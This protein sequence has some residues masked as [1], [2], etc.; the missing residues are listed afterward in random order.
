MLREMGRDKGLAS[1]RGAGLLFRLLHRSH[2]PHRNRRPFSLFGRRYPVTPSVARDRLVRWRRVFRGLRMR[3]GSWI[4]FNVGLA[5]THWT[6]Y[7][8]PL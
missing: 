2:H 6:P 8:F 4:A 7:P 3:N 5:P 1:G